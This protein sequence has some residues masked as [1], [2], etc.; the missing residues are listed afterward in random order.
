[1]CVFVRTNPIQHDQVDTLNEGVYVTTERIES[2]QFTN[3][4]FTDKF[5]AIY[6][7]QK[8]HTK[9]ADFKGI[10]AGVAVN[11][12]LLSIIICC[13]L[14]VLF[15]L[16]EYVNPSHKYNCWHISTA[17]LPCFNSQVLTNVLR[18]YI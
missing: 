3:A 2:F 10:A 11:V 16:I 9:Y 8:N 13:L 6:A 12:Y 1:M 7:Q 4:Y 18:I 14:V 17:I 5:V 15:A